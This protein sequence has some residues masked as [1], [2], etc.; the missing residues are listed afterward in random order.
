MTLAH[1]GMNVITGNQELFSSFHLRAPMG[2]MNMDMTSRA[3]CLWQEIM[4]LQNPIGIGT[5]RLFYVHRQDIIETA[6]FDYSPNKKPIFLSRSVYQGN[7]ITL[8]ESYAKHGSM[9]ERYYWNKNHVVAIDVEYSRTSNSDFVEPTPWQK[10]EVY[11]TSR[12]LLDEVVIHWLKRPEQPK[13]LTDIAYRRLEK[14]QNLKNLLGLAK[15]KIYDS[16]VRKIEKL[17]L[18]EDVY[19]IAITWSPG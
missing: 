3:N 13:E 14:S 7:H 8:W 10:V 17:E 5:T 9:R 16:I 4:S 1:C 12:G 19:C 15:Q 11:Y 2:I 6:H 18:T